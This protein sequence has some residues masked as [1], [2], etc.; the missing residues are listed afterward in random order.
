MA[1]LSRSWAFS[2]NSEILRSLSFPCRPVVAV[3]AAVQAPPNRLG[4]KETIIYKSPI[5][6]CMAKSLGSDCPCGFSFTTPHGEEDAIAIV[7]LHVSR[8]HKKDYPNGISR[9]EAVEHLKAR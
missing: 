6:D 5:T 8:V 1:G 7:Q 4:K 3:E 2:S 9:K